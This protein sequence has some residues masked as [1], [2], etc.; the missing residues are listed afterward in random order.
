MNQRP[1][2]AVVFDLDGTVIDSLG[3]HAESFVELFKLFG[4]TVSKKKIQSLLRS[5]TEEIYS[6]LHAR[7]LLDLEL[8]KFLEIRREIYY[9]L[10]QTKKMVF[11]DA[12]VCLRQLR[13]NFK[14]GLATNSSRITLNHSVSKPF[15]KQFDATI[16]FSEV[17]RPKPNPEMLYKICRKLAV[18]PSQCAFVGDSVMDLKAAKRCGMKPIAIYRKTGASRKSELRKEKPFSLIRDLKKL[19]AILNQLDSTESSTR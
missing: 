19:P 18:R 12:S 2:R 9:H 3:S 11:P 14:L 15:L 6:K 8:E 17:L 4:K 5:P 16:T 7:Q 10:V 1:I 13:K